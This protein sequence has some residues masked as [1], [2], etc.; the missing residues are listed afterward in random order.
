MI[1]K[2]TRYIKE[3]GIEVSY[4]QLENNGFF[5]CFNSKPIIV[6]NAQLDVITTAVTLLHEVAHFLNG[7]YDKAFQ[8]D[9][10]TTTWNMRPI[11][12]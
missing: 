1:K 12:S 7:D 6:I 9:C 3:L 11:A 4:A 8:T 10:K 5:G 2:I